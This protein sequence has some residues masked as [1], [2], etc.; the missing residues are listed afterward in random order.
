MMTA[1]SFFVQLGTQVASNSLTREVGTRNPVEFYNLAGLERVFH[2]KPV[3]VEAT[4]NRGW[5]RL[6]AGCLHFFVHG[7]RYHSQRAAPPA[8]A[9]T[10]SL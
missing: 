6:P 8:Q 3:L 1:I 4:A 5:L 10:F 9:G 2:A 7:V